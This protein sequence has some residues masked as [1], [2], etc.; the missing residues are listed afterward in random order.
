[1]YHVPPLKWANNEMTSCT[2]AKAFGQ[3]N[4]TNM[5]MAAAM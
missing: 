5:Y 1:M 2:M 4:K 3:T